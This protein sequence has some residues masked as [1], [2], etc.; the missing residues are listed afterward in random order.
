MFVF[1]SQPL[2]LSDH[3][4]TTWWRVQ[5]NVNGELVKYI[6]GDSVEMGSMKEP[7]HAYLHTYYED[8]EDLYRNNIYRRG[9][10]V[11]NRFIM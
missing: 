8:I 2:G 7:I 1:E 11:F 5:Q 3:R 4:F 6:H 9:I 10:C